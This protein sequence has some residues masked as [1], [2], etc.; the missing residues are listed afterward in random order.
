M[1][2]TIAL[3]R[4]GDVKTKLRAFD[5]GA[6]DLVTIPF[7][8]EELVARLFALLR[9]AYGEIAQCVPTIRI[10]ELEVDM[11]NQRCE[12]GRCTSS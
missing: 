10:R 2:P 9:R 3:T 5:S 4:R 12:P 11:L 7:S 1:L 6:D 8:P